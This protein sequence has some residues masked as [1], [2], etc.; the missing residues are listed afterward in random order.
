MNKAAR[1]FLYLFVVLFMAIGVTAMFAPDVI[2]AKLALTP[3]NL[4]GTSELRGL[5]GG[6][7]F[8]FG[9]VLLCG[10][11]C[12]LL[13]PGLLTAMAI[14]MGGVVVGRMVSL[15][16]DHETTFTIPAAIGEGLLAMACW[17]ASKN[18]GRSSG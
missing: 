3:V 11:R 12:K 10:L 14:I 16:I 6:G 1:G 13:A 18:N 17:I 7:F 5:Y 8:G 2:A 9:I 15:A 4:A